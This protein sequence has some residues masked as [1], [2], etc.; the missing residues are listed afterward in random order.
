MWFGRAG[1]DVVIEPLTMG[2]VLNLEVAATHRVILVDLLLEV[3][4][5]ERCSGCLARVSAIDRVSFIAGQADAF[6]ARVSTQLRRSSV[7][8]GVR[9]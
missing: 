7:R 6:I 5:F 2:I 4:A 1:V 3:I 9:L 8:A